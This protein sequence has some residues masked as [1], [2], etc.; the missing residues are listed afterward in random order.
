MSPAEA[1]ELGEPVLSMGS[2]AG[3]AGAQWDQILPALTEKSKKHTKDGH[4]EARKTPLRAI[5]CALCA[6]DSKEC[7][8]DPRVEPSR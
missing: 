8:E 7:P 6:G 4:Q 1:G 2:W 3:C 5:V